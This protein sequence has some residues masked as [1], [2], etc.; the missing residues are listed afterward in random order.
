MKAIIKLEEAVTLNY[1]ID[2]A[3]L[4]VSLQ[5][6]NNEEDDVDFIVSSTGMSLRL[7][8]D[9]AIYD[10]HIIS[11]WLKQDSNDTK[12][13]NLAKH[14]IKISNELNNEVVL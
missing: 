12:L 8:S 1:G 13:R 10:L 6:E 5:A 4:N 3:L 2:K 14:Y 11:E 9:V 7:E